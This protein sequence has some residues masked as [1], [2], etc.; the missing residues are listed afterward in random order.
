MKKQILLATLLAVSLSVMYAQETVPLIQ[1][2]SKT[3]VRKVWDFI[4]WPKVAAVMGV[5]AIATCIG[6]QEYSKR[7][8]QGKTPKHLQYTYA[9]L[10]FIFI[11]T[12]LY[13]AG[14][15][16][17][18]SKKDSSDKSIQ[19]TTVINENNREFIYE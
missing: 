6:V 11:G 2:A 15:A 3:V 17:F 14:K 12:V 1:P 18:F 5:G 19:K 13:G 4:T 16:I 8:Y 9:A 10:G 7:V